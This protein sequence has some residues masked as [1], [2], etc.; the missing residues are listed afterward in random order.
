MPDPEATLAQKNPDMFQRLKEA[1]NNY[2]MY[3]D[4]A[5]QTSSSDPSVR[6]LEKPDDDSSALV[7][8]ETNLLLTKFDDR[9]IDGRIFNDGAL[10]ESER[11]SGLDMSFNAAIIKSDPVDGPV[12]A[13]NGQPLPAG[14][15]AA[16][17]AYLAY[18]NA[19]S[20]TKNFKELKQLME[21]SQSAKLSE[22]VKRSLATVPAEREQETF[23]VYK[24]VLTTRN[25]RVVGGFVRGDKATLSITGMED[26]KKVIARFNMHLENGQWKVGMGSTRV[27]EREKPLAGPNRRRTSS[28][29]AARRHK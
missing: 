11:A 8:A 16:G 22:E 24:S 3:L 7:V 29:K 2:V 17:A 25:A 26:G 19:V 21:A 15:G 10:I 12:T 20:M 18:I 9:I 6:E 1:G 14:G 13:S 5:P 4:L 23:G 27:G 28:G